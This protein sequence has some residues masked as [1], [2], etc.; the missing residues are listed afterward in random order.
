MPQKLSMPHPLR[1]ALAASALALAASPI[2]AHDGSSLEVTLRGFQEVPPI[3]TAATGRFK[4][5][6]DD[7]S[8]QIRY[9]LS[10][11]GL[12]GEARQAHIHF[13]QR[14]VNGGI[15]VW[16]C[17]SATNPDPTGRS[18]VCPAS[19]SVSGVLDASSVRPV[20]AQGIVEND[21]NKF[22][23]AVRA[24]AAYVNLHSSRFPGGE[25]RGQLKAD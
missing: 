11:S 14:G 17:Q 20:A 3:S 6:Y 2:L 24:G 1:S 18:P 7:A 19:G 23:G 12:E 25:L 21:F 15:M 4:A 16:L 13:G 10:Y 5:W 22:V 8:R 9:E